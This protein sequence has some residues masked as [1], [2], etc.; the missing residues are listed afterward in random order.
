MASNDNKEFDEGVIRFVFGDRWLIRRL[1][2]HPSYRSGI[3]K[4]DG[5]KAVDF[6]GIL[7]ENEL[8]F[9]EV[10]D[11]RGHR[12][13]NRSRL[14]NELW[15]EIGQK[16]RDSL[17]CIIGAHRTSSSEP[18]LWE[19]LNQRIH[20][21]RKTIKVI[22]WLEEDMVHSKAAKGRKPRLSTYQN[23]LKKKLRWLTTKVL[24]CDTADTLLTDLRV[25]NL[26]SHE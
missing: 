20:D 10:K 15:I 22:L 3:E 19:K 2:N 21:K 7:D 12:I 24:V 16:V 8:F 6:V 1:D 9:M 4:L 17:A 23:M 25:S 5:T 26:P 13:E 18:E 14:R 11:F